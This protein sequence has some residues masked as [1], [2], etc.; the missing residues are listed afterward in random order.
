MTESV[1]RLIATHGPVL[2]FGFCLLSAIG[3]PVP[4]TLTVLAAGSFIASGEMHPGIVMGVALVGTLIGDMIGYGIGARGGARAIAWAGRRGM[5]PQV[6]KARGLTARWGDWANFVCRWLVTPVAPALNIL[7]GLSGLPWPRFLAVCA[8]GET[9]WLTLYLALG[10][11]FSRSILAIAS[12]SG[13]LGLL[14]LALAVVAGLAVALRR[15][16]RAKP[17]PA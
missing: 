3:L 5:G 2:V 11:A 6:E 9:V 7:S 17:R 15:R 16:A 12:A 4:G 13:D 14:L 8:A 1:L 10:Y